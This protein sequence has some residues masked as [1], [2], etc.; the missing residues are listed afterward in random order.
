M[1]N[2]QMAIVPWTQPERT[3]PESKRDL[4][5]WLMRNHNLTISTQDINLDINLQWR[6]DNEWLNYV[7]YPPR[8][9]YG[10]RAVA[11][12]DQGFRYGFRY[13]SPCP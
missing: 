1:H 3:Q 11:V 7:I 9:W 13:L 12:L 10:Y 2:N 6:M 4:F 8:S 5:K